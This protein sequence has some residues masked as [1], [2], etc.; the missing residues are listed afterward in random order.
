MTDQN[1]KPNFY[2]LYQ[3]VGR[4]EGKLD[5]AL[6]TLKNHDSRINV[7]EKVQD[8]LVGKITIWGAMAGFIG[9]IIT[10]IIGWFITKK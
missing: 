7:V 9:G 5:N 2:S 4:M 3:T 6:D 10:V 1:G 8:E